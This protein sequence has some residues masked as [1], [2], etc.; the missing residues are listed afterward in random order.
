MSDTA[1]AKRQDSLKTLLDRA[2]PSLAAVLPKHL[3]PDKLIKVALVATSRT[4]AL[5][6]CTPTSVL[7]A[8]MTASQL[9]L[10][11]GGVLGS[12]YL[13]PYKSECQLVI[14]YRGLIDLARRSGKIASVEAH[15]VY[16][17]DKFTIR[18]GLTPALEH[19]PNLAGEPGDVVAAYAIAR[20]HDG[21]T[22]VEVMTRKQL[23]AIRTRSRAGNSGPWATDTDEMYRK[24][25]VKRLC[26]YLP[27]SV[28]LASAIEADN[29]AE[30]GEVRGYSDILD[31][32]PEDEEPKPAASGLKGK[33]KA[34]VPPP[35]ADAEASAI[36]AQERAAGEEG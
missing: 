27:L 4:P 5:L 14:G 17:N 16:A 3:N 25:V 18:H 26:K 2:R 10:E 8:V 21:S 36:R 33:L 7:Q 11:P 29:R 15:V 23:D 9:G 19:E 1:L 34:L 20:L 12:A 30:S 22:Q 35:V 24:T 13:V 6:Q 32:P 31:V 28:E